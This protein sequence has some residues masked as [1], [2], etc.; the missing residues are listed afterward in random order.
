VIN[1]QCPEDEKTYVHRIG[2]TGRAGKTGVAVT[3]VDWDE[4]ARWK[5]ISDTLG[6][7]RSAPVETYSTSEHLY[8]DLDIPADATGRLPLAK[9]T[10]AGLAAEEEEDLGDRQRSGGR[11][12]QRN[13]TRIRGGAQ[14]NA[15]K[16]G[17]GSRSGGQDGDRQSRG[18]RQHGGTSRGGATMATAQAE[19][20]GGTQSDRSPRRRRR[21]RGGVDVTG[22]GTNAAGLNAAGS[23][24]SGS[25]AGDERTGASAP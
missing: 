24:C 20:G 2:R 25:S 6:L 16:S 12:R 22:G 5:L 8:Q 18:R 17:T 7:D 13:R 21:R 10:R 4:E 9:R 1:Y 14:D 15:E 3:L 11:N 23:G 19:T